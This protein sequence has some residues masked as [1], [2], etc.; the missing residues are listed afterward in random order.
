MTAKVAECPWA[1]CPKCGGQSGTIAPKY[2]EGGSITKDEGF[3]SVR[4]FSRA[5]HDLLEWVC[6]RCGFKDYSDALDYKPEPL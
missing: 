3:G 1:R 2:V 4:R 6:R 5:N